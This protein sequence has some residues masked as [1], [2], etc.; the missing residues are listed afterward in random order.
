MISLFRRLFRIVPALFAVGVLFLLPAA[1]YEDLPPSNPPFYGGVYITGVTRE[2]GSVTVYVPVNYQSGYLGLTSS[3]NLFNTSSSSISGVLYQGSTE[4]QF[5]LS[6]WSEPQYRLESD[7]GS[8]YED[9]TF[10][11]IT[12]SNAEISDSFPPLVSADSVLSLVPL[13]FLGGILLCL[14]MKRF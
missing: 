7:W 3:G 2:L 8:S 5:R 11:S 13:I 9:L 4:Y 6:S 1:A 14:F 10:T 12:A